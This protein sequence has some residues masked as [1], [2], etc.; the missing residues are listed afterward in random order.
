MASPKILI[1]D[2]S[3]PTLDWIVEVLRAAGY[4]PEAVADSVAA[5]LAIRTG[6]YDLVISDIM[7]PELL[8]TALLRLVKA[9]SPRTPVI[10]VTGY[11][12][13]VQPEALLAQGAFAIL[14]KPFTGN[15]L[16]GQV[17]AA[18]VRA[19]VSPPLA[20]RQGE[21]ARDEVRRILE[22]DQ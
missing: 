16:L 22:E 21:S 20:G 19:G 11:L 17:K 18:L 13:K 12:N 14:G 10:L 8:G 1:V 5:A 7:M 2:D 6:G 3:T 15:A 4:A 9:E